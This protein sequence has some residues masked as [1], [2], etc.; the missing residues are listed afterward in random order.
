MLP[1]QITICRA[2]IADAATLTALGITTFVDAFAADNRK[3]DMDKYIAEEMNVGKITDE[4]SDES[5][6]FYLSYYN[7]VLVGYAKMRA[8]K[9]PKGLKAK[10]PIELERIYVLQD[11]QT[12]KIGAAL[13]NFCL[14]YAFNH[15]HDVMWLGVWK[16]NHKA[17]NFYKKWGFEFFGSHTFKLGDDVQTDELMM[18]EL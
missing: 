11:Y 15:K 3:E 14:T 4:L 2:G 12:K 1:D 5:N 16:N 9:K 8:I 18:K 10:H 17:I 13:L 7:K 6:L